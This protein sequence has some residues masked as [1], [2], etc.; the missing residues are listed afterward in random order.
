MSTILHN[1]GA[2]EHGYDRRVHI[3]GAAEIVL[4]SCRYY[5]NV[6]GEKCELTDEMKSNLEYVIINYAK[7]ALRTICFAYKDL[8]KGEGGPTHED[9]DTDGVIHVIERGN[10]TLI[11]VI[12][13][14]DI[15]R[16]EV[17]KAVAIC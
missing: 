14:K 7:Q 9:M 11:S 2:T 13:I 6:D 10:L 8:Q 3:K 1:V 16:P 5:L 4:G 12:G 17:P 15:I